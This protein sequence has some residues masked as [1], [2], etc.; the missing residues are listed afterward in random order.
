MTILER[1]GY[2]GYDINDPPH[3]H[4]PTG[5][6][7]QETGPHPSQIET[8]YT[9]YSEQKCKEET[10]RLF[11]SE[12]SRTSGCSNTS[13]MIFPRIRYFSTHRTLYIMWTRKPVKENIFFY[14]QFN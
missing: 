3:E 12:S 2:D 8:V 7:P 10:I 11:L 9:E 4:Q 6:K 1:S 14:K 5:N 13:D